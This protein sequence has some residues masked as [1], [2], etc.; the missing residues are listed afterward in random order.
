MSSASRSRSGQ[1]SRTGAYLRRT[2]SAQAARPAQERSACACVSLSACS[3]NEAMRVRAPALL[4]QVGMLS[5]LS[6]DPDRVAE[7]TIPVT[8][9]HAT[10]VGLRQGAQ[11]AED[12]HP[13]KCALLQIQEAGEAA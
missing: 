12:R 1:A 11:P 13:C 5:S 7:H 8:N 3:M 6:P 4:T 2:F 10:G 9:E